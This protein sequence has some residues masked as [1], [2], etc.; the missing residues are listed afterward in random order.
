MASSI[1]EPPLRSYTIKLTDEPAQPAH[2][3][4]THAAPEQPA[5]LPPAP[6]PSVANGPVAPAAATAEQGGTNLPS[7]PVP[8]PPAHGPVPAPTARGGPS[9]GNADSAGAY[10]VQLGSFASRAN[11]ERLAKQLHGQGFPVSVLRGAHL[12]R[13]RVG[14][15]HD[16]PAASELAQ[17]LRA[18]GHGGGEIVPK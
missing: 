3:V 16:R 15:A 9:A 5:P 4:S 13:V 10:M 11:A 14:P 8:A 18:H 7:L 6:P 12:Y 1:E 17:Q 2:G